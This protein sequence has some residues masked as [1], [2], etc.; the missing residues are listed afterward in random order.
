MPPRALDRARTWYQRYLMAQ[1]PD[2][3]LVATDETL[4]LFPGDDVG[5]IDKPAEFS[6]EEVLDGKTGVERFM[7]NGK[8]RAA[9]LLVVPDIWMKYEFFPFQPQREALAA[10]FLERK[11]VSLYPNLPEVTRF[12][13]FS[14]K[15]GQPEGRGISAFF[16]HEEKTFRLN[17]ALRSMKSEP[18]W[19][20]TPALLWAERLRRTD[21]NFLK[22]GTLLVDIRADRTLLYFYH[23]GE[24]LFSRSLVMPS[25]NGRAE[26]LLFEINQSNY[27]YAQKTKS[28]LSHIWVAG[29][30]AAFRTDVAAHI[31]VPFEE[32][33][34][35]SRRELPPRLSF[36]DGIWPSDG[37][38]A[39]SEFGS[40]TDRK[41]R[42]ENKW[43]PVQWCGILTAI[44]SIAAFTAVGFWLEG[45]LLDELRVK[46][47][48]TQKNASSL[49]EI[50]DALHLLS[51][52][53]ERMPSAHVLMQIE[54]AR[55][56]SVLIQEVKLDLDLKGLEL[57]A[58]VN[59]E[60]LDQFRHALKLFAENL[61]QGLKLRRAVRLEDF[62][63]QADAL[64][65]PSGWST[66]RVSVKAMME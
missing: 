66:F 62:A 64:R 35:R 19:I 10:A 4:F 6:M 36:L 53:A 34:T 13:T 29:D 20:T 60:H 37:I 52:H 27:L 56:K 9:T 44:V 38:K 50:E 11:L 33:E 59:A 39:P 21:P 24:F 31:E 7:R 1:R 61:N 40:I 16:P 32:M 17:D 12:Y 55:P 42:N 14:V 63:F 54:A 57:T 46:S 25:E 47:K 8:N 45:R 3:I 30:A 5:A 2:R 48:L 26:T 18:R 43:K 49:A 23:Q 65:A 41:I 22:R 15:D 58:A 28:S 51:Q